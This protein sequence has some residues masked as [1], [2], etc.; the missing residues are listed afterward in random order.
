MIANESLFSG[1]RLRPEVRCS[2]FGFLI[3]YY[4]IYLSTHMFRSSVKY[5]NKQDD[6]CLVSPETVGMS[7]CKKSVNQ[8]CAARYIRRLC[9][10][11]L[12]CFRLL[13]FA[14]PTESYMTQVL[15]PNMRNEN[16]LQQYLIVQSF[17]RRT[18]CTSNSLKV[19][20]L[21]PCVWSFV[22]T[23]Q[24]AINSHLVSSCKPEEILSQNM[25]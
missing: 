6:I 25:S 13:S 4:L 21:Q 16:Q 11:I 17:V 10:L 5:T 1:R 19:P 2:F 7:I 15:I 8:G 14:A 20:R 12:S 9:W 22:C 3:Y 18:V 23:V 24:I